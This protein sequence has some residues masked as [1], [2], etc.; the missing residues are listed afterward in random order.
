M[1]FCHVVMQGPP[2]LTSEV[3]SS[4]SVPLHVQ[5]LFKILLGLKRL[6]ISLYVRFLKESVQVGA[7]AFINT[8]GPV[9]GKVS[10]NDAPARDSN[11]QYGRKR[12]GSVMVA[13]VT[14]TQL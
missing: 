8:R 14:V 4:S 5:T 1:A 9:D 11:K 3:L 7:L 12:S 2:S 13:M 10:G 6:L